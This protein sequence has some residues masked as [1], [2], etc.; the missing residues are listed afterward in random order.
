MF[1]LISKILWNTK[2]HN[3]EMRDE[4]PLIL[5]KN[6]NNLI[7]DLFCVVFSEYRK[8]CV[9]KAYQKPLQSNCDWAQF[10]LNINSESPTIKRKYKV[11]QEIWDCLL[12]LTTLVLKWNFQNE[13][14]RAAIHT[15]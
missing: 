11:Q 7:T 5:K 15:L 2:S 12:V 6:Y 1:R 14:G 8:Y 10:L 3:M 13:H 9:W 4:K